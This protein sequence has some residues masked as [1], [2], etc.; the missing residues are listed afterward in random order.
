M[1]DLTHETLDQMLW[2]AAAHAAQM[3]H[4]PVHEAPIMLDHIEGVCRQYLMA[5]GWHPVVQVSC[6]WGETGIGD[7]VGDVRLCL[8]QGSV[9]V[10]TAR[11]EVS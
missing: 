4:D 10:Y 11:L 8:P 7:L 3:G 6:T 9:T 2:F 5:Q 1:I